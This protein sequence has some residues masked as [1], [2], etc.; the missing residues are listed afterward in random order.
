MAR[1]GCAGAVREIQFATNANL[2]WPGTIGEFGR[3]IAMKRCVP[4]GTKGR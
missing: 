1:D 3:L 4:A 2:L